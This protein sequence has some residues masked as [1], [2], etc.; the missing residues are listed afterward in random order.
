MIGRLVTR[1]SGKEWMPIQSRLS[2]MSRRVTCATDV[3]RLYQPP[4]C[5]LERFIYEVGTASGMEDMHGLNS[6]DSPLQR[7][8]WLLLLLS[9]QPIYSTGQSFVCNMAPFSR[10]T[11]QPP[12]G[13]LNMLIFCHCGGGKLSLQDSYSGYRLFAFPSH[14]FSVSTTVYYWGTHTMPWCSLQHHP[15]PTNSFHS[16]RCMATSSGPWNSLVRPLTHE[17]RAGRLAEQNQ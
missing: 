14:I 13:K 9:V 7:L 11:S 10:R 17:L 4:R 12:N 1:S 6:I 16:E 5:L 15:Q 2:A 3:S 8:V